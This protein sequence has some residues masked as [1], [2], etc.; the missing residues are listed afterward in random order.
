MGRVRLSRQ[1]GSLAAAGAAAILGLTAPAFAVPSAPSS[2]AARTFRVDV[3]ASGAQASS[4]SC[5]AGTG[6]ACLGISGSGRYVTFTSD[7]S[8]L[9]AGDTNG[10]SDVFVRDRATG[11]VTRVSVSSSGAQGNGDSNDPA[12]TP[13]G[14]FVAFVSDA[15]NL[16]PGDTNG[17]PD[18][19]VHDLLTGTTDRVSLTSTGFQSGCCLFS[20]DGVAISADGRYVAFVSWASDLVPGDTNGVGDVFI[21]DRAART[22]TRVSVSSTG[23]QADAAVNNVAISA[24]GRSVAFESIAS[25]LVPNDTNAA[26]DVFVRDLPTGTTTRVSVSSS[27]AQTGSAAG[28]SYGPALSSD[29]RYVAFFSDA[30][31]LVPHDTNRAPDVFVHDRS[32]GATTRVNLSTS[33]AQ[34]NGATFEPP[35][36]SADGRYVTFSSSASNLG[37]L[38][39]GGCAGCQQEVFVRDLFAGLTS[40]VSLSLSGTLPNGDSDGPVV[41]ADGQHIVFAS[42]ATDLVG[43]DTNGFEDV[44]VDDLAGA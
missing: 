2:Q 22:T 7:A 43:H 33:G 12:M 3:S 37:P 31:T 18:V 20:S 36:I 15:P 19:F 5:A 11:T 38:G 1:A 26:Y 42:A 6:T 28:G 32:T 10:R 39:L 14:R 27:G 34:A 8:N 9:V 29:G 25:N 40:Q 30:T 16:V 23:T 17:L 13:D 35:A 44:F 21:R 4:D 41:S 24:D